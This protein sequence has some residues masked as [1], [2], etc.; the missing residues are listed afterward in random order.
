MI[1]NTNTDY[2]YRICIVDGLHGV[3]VPQRF[4]AV[5]GAQ[6]SASLLKELQA[7]PNSEAYWEAW[8]EVLNTS[9]III[10]GTIYRL[11]QDQDLFAIPIGDVAF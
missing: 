11:E 3:Y 1:I 4:A 5:Y 2:D 6:V 10:D 7:G 8:E 9:N